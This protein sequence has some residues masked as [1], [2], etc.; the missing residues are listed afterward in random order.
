MTGGGVLLATLCLN[1]MEWLPHLYAQHRD[2]PDLAAWVFVEAADRVYAEVNSTRVTAG[3]LSVDGTSEFLADLQG[4]D[5]RVTYI[6]HGFTDHKDPAKGKIDARQ[7]YMD[8]AARVQPEFVIVL[9]ADEFYTREDQGRLL[10]V[11]RRMRE[12][13][14]FIFPKR[15]IWRPPA[16]AHEPLFRY[17]VVG[18]FW[19]I[20]CCHWWR[21][22]PGV[23]YGDCHNTPEDAEGRPLND[24]RAELHVGK[25][26][27]VVPQMLHLGYAASREMRLAKNLYYSTRGEAVDKQRA[28]YVN[29]RS[30]WD[31]WKPGRRLPMDA[32]VVTYQGPVPE[33]FR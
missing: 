4:R 13:A 18:G 3:G 24:L 10:D 28:W 29:S 12:F 1:E 25:V 14:S 32:Q 26:S 2:W 30:A 9:D 6:P 5:P 7:R 17:E 11:M 20:A 31:A 15:E 23:R 19:G 8:V 22:S 33:V 27:H 21:W 16:I